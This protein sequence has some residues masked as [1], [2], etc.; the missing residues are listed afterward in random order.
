[1]IVANPFFKQPE[2]TVATMSMD[3]GINNRAVRPHVG[4]PRYGFQ[5]MLGGTRV[6]LPTAPAIVGGNVDWTKSRVTP[7]TLYLRSVLAGGRPMEPP[8]ALGS[9]LRLTEPT[10]H[11]IHTKY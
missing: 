8:A 2:K 4:H 7:S 5:T 1:M 10:M 9:T 6:P 11:S 3:T